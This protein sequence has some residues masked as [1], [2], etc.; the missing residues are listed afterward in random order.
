MWNFLTE[1]IY[2]NTDDLWLHPDEMM[3][4]G[5]C[6]M[7]GKVETSTQILHV[8]KPGHLFRTKVMK[9]DNVR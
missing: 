9:R 4:M 7:V 2:K 5:L 8:Y 6:D 3:R 1:T